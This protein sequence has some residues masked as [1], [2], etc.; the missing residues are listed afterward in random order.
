MI[1]PIIFVLDFAL[2]LLV[3]F[4]FHRDKVFLNSEDLFQKCFHFAVLDVGLTRLRLVEDVWRADLR[5]G[6]GDLA[7]HRLIYILDVLYLFLVQIVSVDLD[8]HA[9][10]VGLAEFL[11][12]VFLE[13]VGHDLPSLLC[14]IDLQLLVE[15]FS[16][17][18]VA[19]VEDGE[20]WI[21]A[22]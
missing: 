5:V 12:T 7:L 17:L 13:D 16:I 21:P 10:D 4:F 22:D 9:R 11:A 14:K 2:A 8:V 6:D 3:D 15:L 1:H 18:G 19:L 20:G